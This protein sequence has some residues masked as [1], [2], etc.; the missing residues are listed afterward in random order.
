MVCYLGNNIPGSQ[1]G[2]VKISIHLCESNG[3]VN[4]IKYTKSDF[5]IV[6]KGN[7]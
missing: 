5:Q 3:G 4:M 2:Q 6:I 1:I 7:W